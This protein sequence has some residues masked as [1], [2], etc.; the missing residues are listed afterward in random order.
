MPAESAAIEALLHVDD[1]AELLH[2]SP[3]Q[4]RN[5]RARG[6]LPSAIKIPGL[7]LRW[8]G[9]TIHRWVE[10]LSGEGDSV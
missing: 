7:G 6:Q 2:T 1:L 9:A 10:T 8:S 4:V 5:M 3:R